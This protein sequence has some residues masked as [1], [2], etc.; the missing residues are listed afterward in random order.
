MKEQKKETCRK[1]SYN[2]NN[3]KS[4]RFQGGNY[5]SKKNV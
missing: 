2:N 3:T 5:G 4:Q 1:I